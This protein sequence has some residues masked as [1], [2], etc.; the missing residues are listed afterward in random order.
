M[1]YSHRNGEIT[2]PTERGYYWVYNPVINEW[3]IDCYLSKGAW[4]DNKHAEGSIFYGPLQRPRLG[5]GNFGKEIEHN[6]EIE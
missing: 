3:I 5:E 6:Q 4:N 2:P 1:N